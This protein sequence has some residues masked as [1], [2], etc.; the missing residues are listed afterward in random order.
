MS[1]C[2]KKGLD[3]EPEIAELAVKRRTLMEEFEQLE[4]DTLLDFHHEKALAQK[5][6]ASEEKGIREYQ[7]AYFALKFAKLDP[8]FRALHWNP[9][10]NGEPNKAHI[11]ELV[12]LLELWEEQYQVGE[13]LELNPTFGASALWG[14]AD[15]DLIDDGCV[16]DWKVINDPKLGHP[17]SQEQWAQVLAYALMAVKDGKPITHVAIY[18]A[19][20]GLL[21]KRPIE[22]VCSAPIDVA[23]ESTLYPNEQ[24]REASQ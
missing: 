15:A 8:Y 1:I 24:L 2:N 13:D 4:F 19:R 9:D 11:A 12:E 5:F 20:H 3:F 14:G 10:W 23:I 16:V 6:V 21:L 7:W 22:E 17:H 18:Y